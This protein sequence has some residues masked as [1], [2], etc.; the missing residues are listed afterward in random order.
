MTSPATPASSKE[1]NT[2]EGLDLTPFPSLTGLRPSAQPQTRTS[3]KRSSELSYLDVRNDLRRLAS[4]VN[5][6][7]CLEAGWATLLATVVG[8]KEEVIFLVRQAS[9][10]HEE[11]Q[12]GGVWVCKYNTGG[13][14]DKRLHDVRSERCEEFRH[15]SLDKEK[16]AEAELHDGCLLD[17]TGLKDPVQRRDQPSSQS[18]IATATESTVSLKIV[19]DALGYFAFEISYPTDILDAASAGLLLYQ[20]EQLYTSTPSLPAR[21]KPLTLPRWLMSISNDRPTQPDTFEPLHAQF[22][23]HAHK[24]PTRH[25]LDFR[26]DLEKE[27]SELNTYW[28][29]TQLNEKAEA[30]ASHLQDL[31]GPLIDQVVPICMDRCPEI[32]VA[33]LGILKAG[34]AWCPIDP[35]FPTKRR[36]SLII[37]AKAK[38]LIVNPQS[39]NDGIPDNITTTDITKIPPP[40]THARPNPRILPDSL[41]YLIWTSGT[42]GDP[43]GVPITHLAA[44]TAM[45]SLTRTIPTTTTSGSP[46]RCIQ[47]S[48]FTFDVFVQDLFYTFHSGGTLLSTSRSLILS[49][50]A[51]L[52]IATNATHAHL[53]PAFG[54]SVPRSSCPSL[55]TVTMIGEKLTQGVADDWSSGGCK[56]YNTYGPAEATI[57]STLRLVPPNDSVQSAN[58]GVPL[59]S[60][61]AYVL[62]PQTR[63]IMPRGGIGELALA[64]PQLA[65]GGYWCDEE[66]SKGRFVQH[67]ELKAKVYMTGDVV[68]MLWDE[69]IEFVGREDDLVKIQGIR[70]ELSE[71][72]YALRGCHERTNQ[73]EVMFLERRDRP[74]KVIV[75]YLASPRLGGG[76]ED[77]GVKTGEEAVEIGRAA[78]EAA[79]RELPE[80]MIPKVF[81]V[82]DGIPKT[83]SAKVDRKAMQALYEDVDLGAWEG[84]LGTGD[85]DGTEW[86]EEES[87]IV[88]A[89]VDLTGTTAQAMGR[90]STLPS[91]GVDSITATRLTT[92]LHQ[93]GLEISVTDIL[94]S[95]TL[96]DLVSLSTGSSRSKERPR[97]DVDTFHEEYLHS[98]PA[99]LIDLVELVLPALPLQE[100]MLSEAFRDEQAY[101][102]HNM[103][104]VS[105]SI[106]LNQLKRSFGIVTSRTDALRTAFLS[107]AQLTLR[108][109]DNINSTFLQ[110]T[111]REAPINFSI[112]DITSTSLE[113][114]A[115]TKCLQI[116]QQHQLNRFASPPWA[117]TI[118][119]PS[120]TDSSPIMMLSLHHSIRDEPSLPYLLSDLQ[121]AYTE[122]THL[123]S[124]HQLRDALPFLLP[125]TSQTNLDESFW[126]ETLSPFR[127]SE[128]DAK[129]WPELRLSSIS[130]SPSTPLTTSGDTGMLI[131]TW[132]SPLPYSTL[133]SQSQR[134]GALSCASLLR[135]AFGTLLLSYLETPSVVFGETW[136]R[137]SEDVSLADVI[138]PLITVVPVPFTLAGAGSVRGTLEAMG[139]AQREAMGH[140]GGIHAG[141]VRKL[142]GRGEGEGVYPAVFNF[143]ADAGD[144]DLNI[145]RD[146]EGNE[147]QGQRLWEKRDNVVGLNVEHAVAFNAFISASGKLDLDFTAQRGVVDEAHLTVMAKQMD[148]LVQAMVERP[149]EEM[150]T[151]IQGLSRDVLSVHE[152]EVKMEENEAWAEG[153]TMWVDRHAAGHPDWL[154]AEVATI[155]EEDEEVVSDKWSYKQLYD[156]YRT[157]ASLINRHGCHKRMI[158][159]CLERRLDMYA[160]VLGIMGSNNTYLPIAEDLPGERKA[161]LLQDSDAAIL[162]TSRTMHTSLPETPKGCQVIFV[163]DIDYSAPLPPLPQQPPAQP[164]DNAYLL[165]TSGSTGTPKGVLVSRGNLTTFIASISHF[166]NTHLSMPSLAGRGK[167]LGLASHAFDVHILEM[168][169]PWRHGLATSTAPRTTLLDNLTLALQRLHIT[170]ASFVPSLIDNA[171][172]TPSDVPELR[173]MSVGGE[174]ITKK[175]IETWAGSHVVLANAYGP[176]ELTIGCA[177]RRVRPGSNVR[178]IGPPLAF[179]TAHVLEAEGMGYVLRG[180]P[181]EL[182]MTG[183]LVAN[184]YHNRPDAKGFVEDWDGAGAGGRMYRTGDRVRIMADGTLE[185]LGRSDDQ[186]KIRGQRIELGEVSEAVRAVAAEV[187][188]VGK[189][190]VAAIV[191]QHASLSRPQLVACIV[192]SNVA[193]SVDEEEPRVVD[194]PKEHLEDEIREAVGRRVPAFMVPD[195]LMMLTGLPL[196]KISRKIDAKKLKAMFR[197]SSLGGFASKRVESDKR[198]SSRPLSQH[199]E[200]VKQVVVDVLAK[201]DSNIGPDDNLFSY[202]LDS[203]NAIN[204][205]VKLQKLGYDATVS[206]LLKKPTISTLANLPLKAQKEDSNLSAS[207]RMADLERRFKATSSN[208]VDHSNIAAVLPCLPLQETLIASSL[209][210]EGE[211]LYVNHVLLELTQDV[212]HQRLI[213][214]WQRTAHE[215]DILRTCFQE[216]DKHFVQVILNNIQLS[217]DT[218]ATSTPTSLIADLKERREEIAE[219]IVKNITSRPPIKLTLASTEDEKNAL[220]LV[221]VHH[222]LYDAESFSMLLD[223]VFAQY[224]GDMSS[225]PH[226]HLSTLIQHIQSQDVSRAKAYW[227]EYLFDHQSALF[228]LHEDGTRD[229]SF[230]ATHTLQQPFSSIENLSASLNSTPASLLQSLFGVSLAELHQTRDI[231]FGTILSGRTVPIENADTILAPC[232]TT[233]PQRVRIKPSDNLAET[234]GSAQ[235]GFV[236]SLEHQ[237]TALRD[238]HRW[239]NAEKPLF[240]TLF[241]YTKKPGPAQ[242]ESLWKEL[243]SDMSGEFPLAIEVVADSQADSVLLRCNH[244]SAFGKEERGKAFLLRI[245]ELLTALTN[246][247]Q[248]KPQIASTSNGH[249]TEPIADAD[250]RWSEEEDAMQGLVAEVVGVDSSDVKKDASFFSLGIDSIVAIQFAKR[251]KG[252]GHKCSSADVMRYS[253]IRELAGLL[254][255]RR[256]TNEEPVTNGH[257][258]PPATAAKGTQAQGQEGNIRYP[259]TPL[260]SSMLTQTLGSDGS[261]YVHQHILRLSDQIRP[262]KVRSSWSKLVASVEILRTSFFFDEADGSWYGETHPHHAFPWYI[263]EQ[264]NKLD[265]LL[266]T[267]KQDFVFTAADDFSDPPW[268]ADTVDNIFILSMHHSLYD[269]E[270]IGMLFASFAKLLQSVKIPE[271]PDFSEAAKEINRRQADSEAFWLTHLQGYKG[272]VPQESRSKFV[273]KRATL[274]LKVQEALEGCKSLGVTLQSVALLAYAQTLCAQ[275]QQQDVVFG[276][277]VSGRSLNLPDAENTIGPLFNTVPVRINFS[278]IGSTNKDAAQSIQKLTGTSQA[279]QHASLSGIQRSWR[280]DVGRDD[281][282]MFEAVFVFQRKQESTHTN[283]LW[284]SIDVEDQTAP[285]EYATNLAFEQGEEQLDVV[286]NSTVIDN[287]DAFIERFEQAVTDILFQHDKAPIAP[288]A[289]KFNGTATATEETSLIVLDTKEG[290]R[291]TGQLNEKLNTV[292][293]VLAAMTGLPADKIQNGASIFSLG[294]DSISAIQIASRCRKQSLKVGVADILQGRTLEGIC[295]RLEAS[296]VAPQNKLGTTKKPQPER[297]STHTPPRAPSDQEEILSA[298]GLRE[299][300]VEDILQCLP[301][302]IYHLKTWLSSG[303]TM[304]EATFA[305]SSKQRLDNARL[306]SAWRSLRS[307]HAMLRTVFTVSSTKSALQI[308]LK[309]SAIRSDSFQTMS[310]HKGSHWTPKDLIHILASRHFDLFSPPV[311]L[312][313]VQGPDSDLILLKL[314]HALYDA[315]TIESLI[316]DLAELYADTH[317]S[318]VQSIAPYVRKLTARSP[319]IRRESETYWSHSLAD[320]KPTLLHSANISH[321]NGSQTFHF[322][323]S[324]IPSLHT[325]ETT[326]HASSLSLPTLILLAIARVLARHTKTTNP[327]FGLFQTGR[328]SLPSSEDDEEEDTTTQ[329]PLLPTLNL[330][331]LVIRDATSPSIPVQRAAESLQAD[332]AARVPFEQSYLSDILSA[333][334]LNSHNTENPEKGDGSALFN[335]FVNIIWPT[336]S[337]SSSHPPDQPNH[338]DDKD[339]NGS[340]AEKL[341]KLWRGNN[342]SNTSSS[343]DEDANED[344]LYHLSPTTPA[345][346]RTAVDALSP[347]NSTPVSSIDDDRD[348]AERTRL[349]RLYIDIVRPDATDATNSSENKGGGGGGGVKMI[350]RC[351]AAVMSEVES[352]IF[353][354][355]VG[356]EVEAC[357]RALQGGQA[358]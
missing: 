48:Q 75:A 84:K 33:I 209:N 21:R 56:L 27:K 34:G 104:T 100:A 319:V 120:T 239:V 157:V 49:R 309:P 298:V 151:L 90:Q 219:Q 154:A 226:T 85:Q 80:Y 117:V 230:A 73:V 52:T 121:A 274:K 284:E 222:A 221:S 168:F 10:G 156:A 133:Q 171:G 352:K 320:V 196:V 77:S 163:E 150:K 41:A 206:A 146:G 88:T 324:T 31:F 252:K 263:H 87:K 40:P 282:E 300:D 71:I 108:E 269:G 280:E 109:E 12:A 54:A 3:S 26:L 341:F 162:F 201:K 153:P 317:L 333:I 74:S 286:L 344:E 265:D 58:V 247:E 172:L 234:L 65:R 149:D 107:V 311:K 205:T 197:D 57:V 323:R 129:T 30:L 253:T 152:S 292:R 47:F 346:G 110:T 338:D 233:I 135:C 228:P 303:R 95:R 97:F 143:V 307:R 279:H 111:L 204:L 7:A 9:R 185:F 24:H 53:T 289:P 46:L 188:S 211:V 19:T 164:T 335:V 180:T 254:A 94:E 355:E 59:P 118:L 60:V 8:A 102:S 23:H 50:F 37:R 210:H 330:L 243:E 106:N 246:R 29:Y 217:Y 72:A 278:S 70:I 227:T 169:F 138:G 13:F 224:Q 231:V 291:P 281:V 64:G 271:S 306:L 310:P 15:D 258:H 130:P 203:L 345:P 17:F 14:A 92:V 351:D 91:I 81:L 240:D 260:Q 174:A 5:V 45:T 177:F 312:T 170:H 179:S 123:P 18:K 322:T 315:W 66:R 349:G 200:R 99:E 189:V 67:E 207:V 115:K 25:A 268:R 136:S 316:K 142:L 147:R 44:S 275:Y 175:A 139:K 195:H 305:Y 308:I 208:G 83:S 223:E 4:D 328:A 36:H 350:A 250:D 358:G 212:N 173:Y 155:L 191:G 105:S 255:Q 259:C 214:A 183:P 304:E 6:E 277:V 342:S 242:W 192:V 113:Q 343:T 213:E 132:T 22:E 225:R 11:G 86:T 145:D 184:G 161:F 215:H 285:T 43:K 336:S 272:I 283:D 114:E 294:L 348:A 186:T 51:D 131:H 128:D 194:T 220:L 302:Q 295:D 134:A 166:I 288:Q 190:E 167:Y 158:G 256:S 321:E 313:H 96:N 229:S 262:S 249:A 261:L 337:S 331:P 354:D 237:H 126:S 63:E 244:T 103:Y 248:L 116:A 318:A 340:N 125:T 232:I 38:I 329:P 141:V 276:H 198:T 287:L 236:D 159:V 62:D 28:T 326:A 290:K 199:E 339:S 267:V 61:A 137:R 266:S 140:Y 79:E 353:L 293:H 327:V 218:I 296:H 76:G 127:S 257:A 251:L 69:T 332:L 264:R 2:N 1:H 216:F 273:K 112:I 299:E 82:V 20:Y 297:L 182:C 202:G 187:M 16:A 78:L 32:Y 325:L 55:E 301:G 181:G 357:V 193:E 124:R 148:A 93:R 119:K 235:Q 241:S 178:D 160:V 176:T 144:M 122:R 270:G 101:W 356:E 89:V 35:S 39:P 238:I 347:P 165:Y 245:E 42:T 68:R 98:L 334:K 314:H